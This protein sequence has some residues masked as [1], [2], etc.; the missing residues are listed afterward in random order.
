METVYFEASVHLLDLRSFRMTCD[1][2]VIQ[3]EIAKS[4]R[5]GKNGM[6]GGGMIAIVEIYI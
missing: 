6:Y 3:R 1:C 5:E 4:A 2:A